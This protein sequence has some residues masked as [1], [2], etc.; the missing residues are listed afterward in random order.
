MSTFWRS[1]GGS[2]KENG[3]EGGRL[4]LGDHSEGRVCMRIIT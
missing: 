3:L 2:R 1:Y 4:Q